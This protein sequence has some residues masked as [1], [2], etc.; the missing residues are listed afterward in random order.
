MMTDITIRP[1]TVGDVGRIVDVEKSAALLFVKS[2]YPELANPGMVTQH[3]YLSLF[4]SG[5]FGWVALVSNGT[6]VGFTMAAQ[7]GKAW[8]LHEISVEADFQGM[9]IG[10]NLLNY[11]IA[12]SIRIKIQEISLTTYRDVSWNAPLYESLGFEEL[13]QEDISNDLSS[14]LANEIK[15]GANPQTRIA[16]RILP[17]NN[18]IRSG[19]D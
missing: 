12:E 5:G 10:R 8:H 14:I 15:N 17:G 1:M 16:M 19:C 7:L 18:K 2:P 9:G 6:I 13:M 4:A 11:L 3:R